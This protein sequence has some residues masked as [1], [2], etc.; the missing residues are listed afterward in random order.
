M[1]NTSTKA[2]PSDVLFGVSWLGVSNLSTKLLW[3]ASV[4]VLT[5]GLG[6]A[7]YGQLA[8]IWAY[9]GLATGITDLG[10]G[11]AMFRTGSRTPELL[12]GYFKVSLRLK[13]AL[14]LILWGTVVAMCV[15]LLDRQ[16][17]RL[18]AWLALIVL[19]SGSQLLDHFH[20]FFAYIMQLHGRVDLHAKLRTAGFAVSLVAF[21][22]IISSGGEALAISAVHVSITAIFIILYGW[23]ARTLLRS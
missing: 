4:M 17:T 20:S 6:P 19:A 12:R 11:Q 7:G 15:L 1:S 8:A 16:V 21:W 23:R 13:G 3:A 2:S 9:A 10:A 18:P 22:A 14:T 5:R